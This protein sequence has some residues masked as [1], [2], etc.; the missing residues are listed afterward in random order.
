M[1]ELKV[2]RRPELRNPILVCAFKGWNDAA[3]SATTALALVAAQTG[4]ERFATIDPDSYFDFQV[5]R[6]TVRLREGQTRE[7]LWPELVFSSARAGSESRDLVFLAGA[8]PNLR[9]RE[10]CDTILVLADQMGIELVVTLGALLADVPHTRPVSITGIAS[11]PEL[12]ERLGFSHTR[13]EGPT[14][15]VG[16]LHDTCT[17]RGLPSASL[18][19]P[20]PHYVAGVPS[21][22]ATLALMQALEGLVDVSFDVSDLEE[23]SA[24]YEQRLDEAVAGEPEVASLVERLERQVDEEE[25]EAEDLPSGEAIAREF[26]RFLRRRGTDKN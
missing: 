10:F 6:P 20:V 8:E 7:I 23:A 1:E 5:T 14:G 3:E 12:V 24:E 25:L 18:W 26:E 21:P 16:V 19:A 13:Y 15:I 22:K 9:W 11:S 4:A 2:E 17:K